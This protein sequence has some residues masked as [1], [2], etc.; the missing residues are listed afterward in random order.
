MRL[1]HFAFDRYTGT[2]T[3]KNFSSLVRLVDPANNVDREVKIWMNHPLRY[4]G[5][6]FYQAGFQPDEKTTILQVVKN[7]GWIMP[8]VACIIGALGMMIHFGI[9]LS[10]FIRK[11]SKARAAEVQSLLE[12]PAQKKNGVTKLM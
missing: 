2:N 6:T 9:K 1:I 5:E 11:K 12:V 10:E 8:Y 7:P 4:R 3:A